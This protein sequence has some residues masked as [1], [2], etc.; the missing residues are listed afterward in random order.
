MVRRCILCKVTGDKGTYRIPGQ[1]PGNDEVRKKWLAVC[2]LQ[3]DADTKNVRVCFR[4]FHEN[5]LVPFMN[6][7]HFRPKPGKIIIQDIIEFLLIYQRG[8]FTYSFK[9]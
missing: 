7:N 3:S 1:G 8:S 4:H 6:H 5:D 2:G 9:N